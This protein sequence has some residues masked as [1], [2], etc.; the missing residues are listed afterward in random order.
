M[1]GGFTQIS[2]TGL[3]IWLFS[4]RNFTVG[5]TYSKTEVLQIAVLG[6]FI[7]GDTLT[8][9][10]GLAIAVAGMTGAAAW[11]VESIQVMT[12]GQTVTVSGYDYTFKGA[13]AIPGPNYTATRGTFVVGRDGAPVAVLHPEKRV[14]QVQGQP[15]TEAGIHST[16]FG[17]L[18]AVSGDPSD[19]AP[20]ALVTRLYFNPL[21]AWMWAG[22][23]IMALGGFLS[24]SDRRYRIGAPARRRRGAAPAPAE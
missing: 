22:A 10:T 13:R 4:F 20:G 11:K 23:L 19:E 1:L 16:F 8:P 7:L 18:D 15:T 17:D 12:P 14:Y 24:L 5:T 2:L 21:V 3:L 9:V 6:F